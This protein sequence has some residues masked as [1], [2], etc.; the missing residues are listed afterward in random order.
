MA[1]D[2]KEALSADLEKVQTELDQACLEIARLNRWRANAIKAAD[3]ILGPMTA[4]VGRLMEEAPDHPVT[5]TAY[6][7]TI[8]MPASKFNALYRATDT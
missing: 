3:A 2:T 7:Q 6:G 8:E 1:N 4:E 5:I